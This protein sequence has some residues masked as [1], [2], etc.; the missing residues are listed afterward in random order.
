MYA[1]LII[2]SLCEFVPIALFVILSELQG[3]IVGVVSLIV[4]TLIS[5]CVAWFVEKHVPRFAIVATV[6]ILS[7]GA[8]TVIFDNPFYIIIKDTVY[9]FGFAAALVYGLFA[10]RSVFSYFF[11][12][13]FAI[14]T[15]GWRTL[16]TRWAL[17]FIVLG[18]GNEVSRALLDPTQWTIYKLVAVFATWVF[19]FYQLTLTKKTRLPDAT[20]LGLRIRI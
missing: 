7:F 12:D 2:N 20:P 6:S 11:G 16:E 14:T 18:V 5:T 13:F 19:G 1:R 10:K 3:F 4:A 8:L 15:E 17:F 9:Y